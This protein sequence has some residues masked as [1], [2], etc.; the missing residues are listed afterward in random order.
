M[1][2]IQKVFLILV[3][4]YFALK[5]ILA[6]LIYVVSKRL[7]TKGVEFKKKREARKKKTV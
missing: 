5:G 6:F 4:S 7:Q 3:V 1:T 2:K